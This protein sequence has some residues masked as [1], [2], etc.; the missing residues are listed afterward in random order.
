MQ[1]KTAKKSTR[2]STT[3]VSKARLSRPIRMKALKKP[4]RAKRPSRFPWPM[5]PR[6]IALVAIGVIVAAM[7]IEAGQPSGRSTL[8]ADAAP[9]D[10]TAPRKI[11]SIIAPSSLAADR[12]ASVDTTTGAAAIKPVKTKSIDWAAATTPAKAPASAVVTKATGDTTVASA[13]PAELLRATPLEPAAKAP[14]AESIAKPEVLP[15][16][17]AVT[18]TGCLEHEEAAF[19]LTDTSGTDVPKARSWKSGFLKKRSAPIVVVDSANM[20][21]LS[22]HVGHRVTATGTLVNREMHARSLQ[23]VAASCS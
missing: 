1:A 16:S 18:I 12:L 20:L 22:S 5:S 11:E 15:S 4:A 23:R 8:A 17:T 21:R 10:T 14:A 2:F 9:G 7:I 19:Q 13:A 3:R 6:A